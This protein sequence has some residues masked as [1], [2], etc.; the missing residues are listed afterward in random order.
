L[1]LLGLIIVLA[2][3]ALL[4]LATAEFPPWGD[5]NSPASLHVSP[6]Y[7]EKTMEET[8]VPNAVTSVLA[9]YRGFDT[10]FETTVIFA[11]GV[12]CFMLLRLFGKEKSET[13]HYRHL[14]TGLTIRVR[15]RREGLE[16]LGEFERMDSLWTPHDIILRTL[17][18]FLIPFIQLFALY[19]IA[20][21]HHSP[22]G[23]FQGGVI[24]GASLILMAISQDMN[25]ALERIRERTLAMLSV[26]GVAIY[27]GTGAMCLLLGSN[28]LDYAA[29][30]RLLWV[31]PV[32]AR[33][34][35]IFLVEVGVGMAVMA[36]MIVIYHNLASEGRL[37]EGL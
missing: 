27:A 12:S 3:G 5:P 31:D 30:A 34:L 21:G 2:T 14:L 29:L 35:G 8:S 32:G 16:Q 10:M 25:S 20:H 24:L 4:I 15:R 18:R 13:V 37:D 17:S 19:V 28:F 6:R 7:I 26:A 9:D 33:S 1:K 23:G 36:T 22:G 11:A